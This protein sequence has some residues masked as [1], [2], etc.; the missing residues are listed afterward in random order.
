MFIPL[1]Y[2]ESTLFIFFQNYATF[3]FIHCGLPR[4]YHQQYMSNIFII[5]SSDE[6][7][8]KYS[9]TLRCYCKST[10]H[11]EFLSAVSNSYYYIPFMMLETYARFRP[12]EK[13]N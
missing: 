4:K 11:F 6:L 5:K 2:K 10:E 12:K 7:Y 13:V 8:T 9:L 1:Q 3:D